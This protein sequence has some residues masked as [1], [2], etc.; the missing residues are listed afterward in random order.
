MRRAERVVGY[1][2]YNNNNNDDNNNNIVYS[3]CM[4]YGQFSEFYNYYSL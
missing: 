1:N 3:I 2:S 4:Y